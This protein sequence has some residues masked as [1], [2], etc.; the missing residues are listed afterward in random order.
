MPG[1]D[2]VIIT[3]DGQDYYCPSNMV[4]YIDNNG[5]NHSNT[6]FTVYSSL[7]TSNSRYPQVRFNS[8][9]YPVL[10]N[11]YQSYTQ[12]QNPTISFSA[13][14]YYYKSAAYLPA[15]E[16]FLM[17]LIFVFVAFRRFKR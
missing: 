15:V 11:S 7:D 10:Y 12:L 5:I 2:L 8:L 6:S 1:D 16:A 9:A 14:A 17:G 3:I 4:Q 13:A